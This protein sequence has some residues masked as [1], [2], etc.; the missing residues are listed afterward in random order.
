MSSFLSPECVAA[1][2]FSTFIGHNK[3]EMFE[4]IRIACSK[5]DSLVVVVVCI[6]LSAT[7]WILK[8]PKWTKLLPV[9]LGFGFSLLYNPIRFQ[10]LNNNQVA[11]KSSGLTKLEWLNSEAADSRTR[12]SVFAS[13]FAATI[14]SANAWITRFEHNKTS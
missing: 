8:F 9:Y 2:S 11:F 13:L 12:L 1:S 7:F 10:M 6:L 3:G 5:L 4:S 14:V